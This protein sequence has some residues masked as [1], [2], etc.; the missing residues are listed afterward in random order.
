MPEVWVS[1]AMQEPHLEARIDVVGVPETEQPDEE[2][3][4]GLE[5]RHHQH[6]MSQPR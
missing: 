6:D 5:V 2:I 3:G 1:I 4:G